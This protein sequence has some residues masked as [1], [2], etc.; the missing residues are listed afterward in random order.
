[1]RLPPYSVSVFCLA[2]FP[3]LCL[4][5]CF[6]FPTL[7][8]HSRDLPCTPCFVQ[9]Y[10]TVYEQP[11]AELAGRDEVVRELTGRYCLRQG[12]YSDARPTPANLTALPGQPCQRIERIACIRWG[13]AGQ[14]G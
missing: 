2:R 3:G 10:D 8:T 7:P 13:G 14:A 12:L 4:S 5:N 9:G 1:M 11:E 6:C